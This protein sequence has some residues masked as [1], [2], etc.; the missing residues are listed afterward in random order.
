M[1][2]PI[3]RMLV[4][5]LVLTLTA[6]GN[7]KTTQEN[8]SNSNTIQQSTMEK[9]TEAVSP[10]EDTLYADDEFSFEEVRYEVDSFGVIICFKF[11]NISEKHLDRASFT[12]QMLDSNSDIID[13]KY[14]G[15]ID[16]IEP[17]QGVWYEMRTEDTK[18]CSSIQELSARIHSFKVVSLDATEDDTDDYGYYSLD[19]KNP[20]LIEVASIEAKD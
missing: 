8:K 12:V 11:R 3:S 13:T 10:T 14:I 6:C 19:F 5:I 7:N 16:G 2:K 18:E 17:G 4:F 20:I 9:I 1:K 15:Y